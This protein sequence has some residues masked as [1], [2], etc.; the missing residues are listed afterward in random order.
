MYYIIMFFVALIK[1]M[2]NIYIKC[3]IYYLFLF[4]DKK[5]ILCSVVKQTQEWNTT[6]MFICKYM[7][8]NLIMKFF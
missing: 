6:L 3:I 5:I 4:I 1:I 2:F 7:S 8:S